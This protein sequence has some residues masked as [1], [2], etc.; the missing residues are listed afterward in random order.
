MFWSAL[1]RLEIGISHIVVTFAYLLLSQADRHLV[2]TLTFLLLLLFLFFFRFFFDRLDLDLL[3]LIFYLGR[4][5]LI[6]ILKLRNRAGFCNLRS[7]FFF[8]YFDRCLS[9][10]YLFFFFDSLTICLFFFHKRF[11][12]FILL[13]YKVHIT[14]ID[15]IWLFMSLTLTFKQRSWAI[16]FV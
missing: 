16:R 15:K 4:R 5:H 14:E 3:Q 10:T 13:L 12:V 7:T 2:A 11:L 1:N 6:K 9:S 8:F